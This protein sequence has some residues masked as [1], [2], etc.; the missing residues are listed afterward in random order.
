MKKIFVGLVAAA[1]ALPGFAAV[2]SPAQIADGKLALEKAAHPHTKGDCEANLMVVGS[3]DPVSFDEILTKCDAA[4][5]KHGFTKEYYIRL[6]ACQIACWHYDG[7]FVAD[8]WKTACL[9]NNSFRWYLAK[10]HQRTL[11]L[12]DA[13]L[14]GIIEDKIF[15]P[16]FFAADHQA[17]GDRLLAH[18]THSGRSQGQK[19]AEKDEP[20]LH[21]EGFRRRVLHARSEHDPQRTERVLIFQKIN[22]PRV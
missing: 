12:T 10:F 13:D 9:D 5:R 3:D 2:W 22:L 21:A 19:R 18:R 17:D 1:L 6:K 15:S 11:G 7:K 16:D 8:A 4:F 20:L 14:A